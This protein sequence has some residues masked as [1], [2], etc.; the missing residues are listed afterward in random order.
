ML[1]LPIFQKNR[2]NQIKQNEHSPSP[3][4]SHPINSTNANAVSQVQLS[5][6]VHN[7][8]GNINKKKA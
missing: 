2:I 3:R 5:Q 7:K 6:S 4:A 1:K 8:G